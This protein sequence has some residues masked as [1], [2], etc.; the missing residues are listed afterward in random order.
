MNYIG[1]WRA[2]RSHN[3]RLY[4]RLESDAEAGGQEWRAQ[5]DCLVEMVSRDVAPV[6]STG[7]TANGA[8]PDH[9]GAE[10]EWPARQFAVAMFSPAIRELSVAA[11]SIACSTLNTAR[12]SVKRPRS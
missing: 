9:H 2:L 5:V 4:K 10:L 8:S 3:R 6:T 1:I 12:E 7:S 11:S